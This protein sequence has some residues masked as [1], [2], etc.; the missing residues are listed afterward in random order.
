MSRFQD[1][2]KAFAAAKKKYDGYYSQCAYFA[3][4]F[5]RALVDGFGWPRELVSWERP[6][7]GPVTKA[8]D[9]LVLNGDTFWH[10]GLRLRLETEPASDA[11][12][13]EL[14][15]KRAGERFLLELFPGVEF[16]LREPTPEA[17]QPVL[18]ALYEE[19]ATYYDRGLE[20]FLENRAGKLHIP[21]TP[22]APRP[23]SDARTTENGK[24][25]DR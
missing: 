11:F 5:S 21:F 10:C 4:A 2:K 25:G 6:G 17:F 16:D 7:A 19:L 22:P 3:G 9:A 12:R 13:L 24:A 20:L 8:E 23:V 14:R 1:V 15:F 18:D